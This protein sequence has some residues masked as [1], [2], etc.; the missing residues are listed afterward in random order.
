MKEYYRRNLPHIH[1]TSAVFFITFRLHGSL[2]EFILKQLMEMFN[3]EKELQR[4]RSIDPSVKNIPAEFHK[5]YF[6]KFDEFLDSQQGNHW[7][8]DEQIARIVYDAIQYRDGKDYDLICYTIMP[9]HIHLLISIGPKSDK[10]CLGE[11][12]DHGNTV[13]T[14]ILHSL[15]RYT[16]FQC[17]KVLQRQGAFWQSESYDRVVRNEKEM[18][19]TIQYILNNPVKAG[20][21]KDTKDWKYSCCKYTT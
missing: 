15:K 17:N 10:M 19:H 14:T 3:S 11:I 13:L 7:L 9:N 5:R 2:P 16:A 1:P 4:L 8:A 6:E 18:E 21:T 20:L 12:P